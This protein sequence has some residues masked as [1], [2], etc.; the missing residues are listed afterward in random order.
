MGQSEVYNIL[1]A[2][3]NKWFR[4]RDVQ[5]LLTKE[6]YTNGVVH[7]APDDLIR[8]ALFGFVEVKGHGIFSHYKEFRVKNT[9]K[10]KK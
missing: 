1:K 3:K 2:N 7:N 8:L 9:K 10:K 5:D 4:A 6:G